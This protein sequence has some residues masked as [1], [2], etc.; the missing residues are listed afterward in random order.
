MYITCREKVFGGPL[1]NSIFYKVLA[2][3]VKSTFLLLWM[4]TWALVIHLALQNNTFTRNS[5]PF[6]F[7]NF[8]KLSLALRPVG[9]A[10]HSKANGLHLVNIGFPAQFHQ[11]CIWSHSN[12][13]Q[14]RAI[15]VNSLLPWFIFLLWAFNFVFMS[16]LLN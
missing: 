1:N 6:N 3:Y 5:F 11:S 14:I 2:F 4:S 9:K 15:F 10:C 13:I 12:C 7:Y 16:F 8:P